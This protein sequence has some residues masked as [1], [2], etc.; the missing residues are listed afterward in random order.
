MNKKVLVNYTKKDGTKGQVAEY[1]LN[2]TAAHNA[3][4]AIIKGLGYE[5]TIDSVQFLP[6]VK[7]IELAPVIELSQSKKAYSEVK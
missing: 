6:V 7:H 5:C 2:E 1:H 3:S 4:N